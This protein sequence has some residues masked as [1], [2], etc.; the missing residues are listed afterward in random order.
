MVPSRLARSSTAHDCRSLAL[1]CISR[2]RS[3]SVAFGAKRTSAS[4]FQ[5]GL[6]STH[7]SKARPGAAQV[8]VAVPTGSRSTLWRWPSC[9]RSARRWSGRLMFRHRCAWRGAPHTPARA[10]WRCAA[11][12]PQGVL[13][14][15]VTGIVGRTPRGAPCGDLS[16]PADSI[17]RTTTI[18]RS[19]RPY[20]FSRRSSRDRARSQHHAG[21]HDA[22][23]GITHVLAVHH[24]AGLL[25]ACGYESGYQQGSCQRD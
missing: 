17:D 12:W 19:S 11:A 25:G 22:T 8:H 16:A 15:S 4:G 14:R 24:G 13:P 7:P 2:R 1:R 10:R 20:R 23:G 18:H 21:P 9:R 6:M 3:N 5:I